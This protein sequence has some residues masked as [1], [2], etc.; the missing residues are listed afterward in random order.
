[1]NLR[2]GLVRLTGWLVALGMVAGWARVAQAQADYPFRDPKLGDGQ[3]IADLLARLT[4][5]EK[6][7]LMSD[8][9]KFP[10][11]GLV[12]SGQVEGLHGLA[13]GGPG[14]MGRHARPA[15][16]AD[17]DL[18][19]GER[20]GRDLGRGTREEDCRAGRLRSAV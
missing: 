20:P 3:R 7:E 13:L 2:R 10:R 8:H 16:A 12:F 4:L 5:D 6:V 15:A 18:P 19:A 14:R 11:L 9:P 17:N 1:M